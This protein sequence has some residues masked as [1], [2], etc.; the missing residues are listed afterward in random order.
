MKT[1]LFVR[2]EFKIFTA[3]K[4]NFKQTK[5]Q[6]FHVCSIRITNDSGKK[7][8]PSPRRGSYTTFI[9]IKLQLLKTKPTYVSHCFRWPAIVYID[10]QTLNAFENNAP[11]LTCP[12]GWNRQAVLSLRG[13]RKTLKSLHASTEKMSR[14][15]LKIKA[16]TESKKRVIISVFSSTRAGT[17]GHAD[18]FCPQLGEL[19][20]LCHIRMK[21]LRRA[22]GRDKFHGWE[23]GGGGAGI[24][25]SRYFDRLS[26]YLL[27]WL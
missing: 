14:S 3:A 1:L 27:H 16:M 7:I 11:T 4:E 18:E 21:I 20:T 8:P 25:Q 24:Y 5:I 22:K 17:E 10:K 12:S 26:W 2:L 6:C 9:N 23:R 13:Q 19:V 15:K